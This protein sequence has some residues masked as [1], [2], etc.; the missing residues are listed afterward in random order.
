MVDDMKRS[1]ELLRATAQIMEILL[2][3]SEQ[4]RLKLIV[5]VAAFSVPLEV[6]G[7]GMPDISELLEKV[8]PQPKG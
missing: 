5:S 2:P 3:F 6:L 1:A 8:K 7:S 4:E